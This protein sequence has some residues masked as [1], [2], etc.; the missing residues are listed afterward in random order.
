MSEYKVRI[1]PEIYAERKN[2]PGNMRQR[3]K[4]AVADLA[5]EPR[6]PQSRTL[7]VSELDMPP[8]VEMRRLRIGRWRVV[9][10]VNDTERWTWVLSLRRRPPYDYDD[11]GEMI[12]KLE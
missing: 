12:A 5:D 10:A 7:D 6:P 2:L 4:R 1:E 9:Y 3:V 11:L 8:E